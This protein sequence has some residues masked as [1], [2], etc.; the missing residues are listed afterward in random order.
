LWVIGE[1]MLLEFFTG[2]VFIGMPAFKKSR[3]CRRILK[4][5]AGDCFRVLVLNHLLEGMPMKIIGNLCGYHNYRTLYDCTFFQG[6]Q[7]LSS[8]IGLGCT[9]KGIPAEG[10]LKGH[11]TSESCCRASKAQEKER[12][13]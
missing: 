1:E 6:I 11:R 10:G 5:A 12:T 9:G 3:I 2:Y 7:A 8:Q 13:W 4:A